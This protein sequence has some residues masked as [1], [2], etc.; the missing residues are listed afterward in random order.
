MLVSWN[1]YRIFPSLGFDNILR[2]TAQTYQNVLRCASHSYGVLTPYCSNDFN[3]PH[4][5]FIWRL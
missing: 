2:Q 3:A 4:E 5:R 1:I